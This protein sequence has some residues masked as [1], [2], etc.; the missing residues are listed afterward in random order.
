MHVPALRR[1]CLRQHPLLL[2]WQW[3]CDPSAAQEGAAWG[4]L[5]TNFISPDLCPPT[6]HAPIAWSY[7]LG[8]WYGVGTART[9]QSGRYG[10]EKLEASKQIT[11]YLA[12]PAPPIAGGGG[13]ALPPSPEQRDKAAPLG[14]GI[15][16][17]SRAGNCQGLEALEGLARRGGKPTPPRYARAG[18]WSFRTAEGPLCLNSGEEPLQHEAGAEELSTRT[19][20]K[21]LW[22]TQGGS[23]PVRGTRAGGKGS[24]TTDASLTGTPTRGHALAHCMGL[25]RGHTK[26]ERQPIEQGDPRGESASRSTGGLWWG[27]FPYVSGPLNAR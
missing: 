4:D 10:P 8:A 26:H 21:P 20:V 3:R 27:G 12:S 23:G 17:P 25:G 13:A 16:P 2:G 1:G 7:H 15:K 14:K 24:P 19:C 5:L 18:S 11:S 6:P 9:T 22:Y